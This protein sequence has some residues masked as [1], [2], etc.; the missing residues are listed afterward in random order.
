MAKTAFKNIN[1]YIGTFPEEVREKLKKIW[2]VIRKNSTK[3]RRNHNF[4]AK[5]KK[6]GLTNFLVSFDIVL[7]VPAYIMLCYILTKRKITTGYQPQAL[8]NDE[9]LV[10]LKAMESRR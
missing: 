1:E 10:H 3:S 4:N 9:N 8:A 6:I 2:V 7:S 5:D